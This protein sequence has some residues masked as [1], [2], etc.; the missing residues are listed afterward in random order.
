MGLVDSDICDYC[1]EIDTLVHRFAVCPVVKLFWNNFII[2][3]RKQ[4]DN[5]NDLT[6][7]NII[8]GFY[9]QEDYALNKSILLAKHFIHRQKCKKG[10]I[11]SYIL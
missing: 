4:N 9:D 5:I 3:W 1:D 6:D 7:K 10:H 2:W 8:L 11:I